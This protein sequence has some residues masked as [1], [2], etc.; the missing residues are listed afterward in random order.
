LPKLDKLMV[1]VVDDFLTEVGKPIQS[2]TWKQEFSYKKRTFPIEPS[3]LQHTDYRGIKHMYINVNESDG[4]YRFM[5]H[6]KLNLLEPLEL[7]CPDCHATNQLP[8]DIIGAP[9]NKCD[10]CG[11]KISY[12]AR[13]VRDLLKRKTID[14]FWGIDSS[15]I[16]L[17]LV[18]GIIAIAAFGGVFY[19]LG[20]NQNLQTQLNKYLPKPEDVKSGTSTTTT[21]THTAQLLLGVVF[22]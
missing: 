9:R 21:T 2:R 13:N 1:H 19:L 22:N 15:H 12:D 7:E 11:D 18:M 17:L 14:T 5:E 10:K 8:L 6:R 4:T 16:L 20:Q 3:A